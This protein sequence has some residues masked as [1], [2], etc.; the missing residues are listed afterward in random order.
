MVLL[1]LWGGL[2]LLGFR[3]GFW[4]RVWGE[5]WGEGCGED[6]FHFFFFFFFVLFFLG[7]GIGLEKGGRKRE[8]LLFGVLWIFHIIIYFLKK[9]GLVF[10][11]TSSMSVGEHKNKGS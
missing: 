6:F 5:V 3:E 1:L 9:M 2:L 7:G 10:I 4:G 11:S 8:K